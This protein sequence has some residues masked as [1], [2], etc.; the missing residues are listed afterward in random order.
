MICIN[1]IPR[2]RREET[3]R[4]RRVLTWAASL[5]VY[6]LALAVAGSAARTFAVPAERERNEL[7]RV[8]EALRL[9]DAQ[10]RE[11]N[12]AC[13]KVESR[14]AAPRQ[15]SARPDWSVV[16]RLVAERR[17]ELLVLDSIAV[18][19]SGSDGSAARVEIAGSGATQ[20]AAS[21]FISALEQLGL[22]SSVKQVES[23]T[24][25]IEGRQ[26]VG[27]QL[28]CTLGPASPGSAR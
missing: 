14:L 3:E 15:I 20:R 6:A 18:S 12:S 21:E 22:F 17:G 7:D 27:F 5:G 1:L 24:R 4:R 2:A 23:R 28:V 19:Q 9:K 26:V 13:A 25:I 10:L 8:R 11:A 16:L